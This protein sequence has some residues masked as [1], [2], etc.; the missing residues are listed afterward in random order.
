MGLLSVEELLYGQD[1][2]SR[3]AGSVGGFVETGFGGLVE[4]GSGGLLEPGE[5]ADLGFVTL[6]DSAEVA[7]L[8]DA[9]SSG[10]DGE[11]S[12]GRNGGMIATRREPSVVLP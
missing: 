6:D 2:D 9:D 12:G 1:L 5:E 3:I 7:D 11:E 8:R 4:H 10:L